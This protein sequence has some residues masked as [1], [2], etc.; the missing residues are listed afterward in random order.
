MSGKIRQK[1][2]NRKQ[3]DDWKHECIKYIMPYAVWRP[4]WV[5]P[6]TEA[7]IPDKRCPVLPENHQ[8]GS[9]SNC[10]QILIFHFEF[11]VL[12]RKIS[13]YLLADS[14]S[15][16]N[17]RIMRGLR[18]TLS[19]SGLR[20]TTVFPASDKHRF[21]TRLSPYQGLKRSISRPRTGLNGPRN[22]HYRNTGRT[23]PDYAPG[24]I[25]MRYGRQEPSLCWI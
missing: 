11:S 2:A 3:K 14:L 13:A 25:R 21:G 1:E 24:Y 22:R 16:A 5:Q 15:D 17:T 23:F 7:T 4:I 9:L 12:P 19:A 6:E 20:P 8:Y 10:K 18:K